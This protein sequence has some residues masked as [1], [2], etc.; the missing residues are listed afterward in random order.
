MEWDILFTSSNPPLGN[1]CGG[2]PEAVGCA[3]GCVQYTGISVDALT[4]TAV[5]LLPLI[6]AADILHF[7]LCLFYR[8]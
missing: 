1:F 8:A 4:G 2:S 3:Y 6:L 7:F 5:S